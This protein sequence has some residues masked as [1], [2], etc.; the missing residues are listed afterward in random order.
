M[1]VDPNDLSGPGADGPYVFYRDNQVIIKS[2]Q[3][4]EESAI[5]RHQRAKSHESLRLRCESGETGDHFWI[6][7]KNKHEVEPY[8]FD[9]PEKLLAVSDIE[10]NFQAYKAILLGAGV[11]NQNFEWTYGKG[12]LVLLGDFFDR[13]LEVTQCLWLSYKLEQ[14]AKAAGGM[15][16][17]ILGN[18]EIMN[19][20]GNHQYVRRKYLEN[21]R[22]M[23]EEY[24]D[25]Y[26]PNTELGRWLRT[27]HAVVRIGEYVFCHGGISPELV[28]S[29]I[30]F[31]QIND[32]SRK[33]LGRDKSEWQKDPLANALYNQQTGIFWYRKSARGKLAIA[34]MQACLDY[35]SART[36]VVGHTLAPDISALYDGRLICIDLLHEDRLIQGNLEALLIQQDQLWIQNDKGDLRRIG[37]LLLTDRE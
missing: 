18:H 7:L 11:I 8:V 2:V 4:G 9:M 34:E 29:S 30:A 1:G 20:S 33:Y 21:A 27:K 28:A 17:F 10:G 24:G 23:A 32:L 26:G 13:G 5:A 19:L 12:H 37:D 15:A 31:D 6:K 25:L 14:E 35:A 16:H 3:A 22:L 36:M